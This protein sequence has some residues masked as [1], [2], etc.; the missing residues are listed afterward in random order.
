[1][2]YK[3]EYLPIGKLK[4]NPEN[5]RLI[6]DAGFKSL[7][8]SLKDCQRLFDARPCLC[9]DRTKDLII[10]AGNMRFLAAK[11]LEYEKIPVIIM[12]GLTETQEREILLKDNGTVWGEWD[13]DLLSAWDDL[14]LTDWG[15][16]L[17]KAW[18][19]EPLDDSGDPEPEKPRSILCPKCNHEFSILKDKKE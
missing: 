7:V 12:S 2:S 5:P 3:I 11:E 17:P 6:R 19:N 13:Y 1:M 15:V 16:E 14:P 9:S 4:V 10:L 18:S 8:K